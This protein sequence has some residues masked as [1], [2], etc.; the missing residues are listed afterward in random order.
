M[1]WIDYKNT[2]YLSIFLKQF[3]EENYE[4]VPEFMDPEDGN[5]RIVVVYDKENRAKGQLKIILIAI[6][7]EYSDL[8]NDPR[9]D[10]FEADIQNDSDIIIKDINMAFVKVQNHKRQRKPLTDIKKFWF[11]KAQKTQ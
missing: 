3:D 5:P 11:Q 9:M 2:Q 8:R 1:P 10:I 7:N 6:K 4:F